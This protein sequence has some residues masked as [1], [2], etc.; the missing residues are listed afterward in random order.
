AG[1]DVKTFDQRLRVRIG[2]G[3]EPSIGMAVAAKKALQPEH[4]SVL[5]AADDHRSARSRLEDSDAA[6]DECAHDA[7]T[8][9]RLCDQQCAQLPRR[10]DQSF[11]WPL[12]MGIHKRRSAR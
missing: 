1:L 9:L 3:I 6:Q 12:R 7:L 2:L 8:Q 5:R 11:N 10:D 4:V